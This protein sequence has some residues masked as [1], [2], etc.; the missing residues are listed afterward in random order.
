MLKR[1]TLRR[2]SQPKEVG[3]NL[4]P[5]LDTLVTLIAF[6]LY[7]MTFLAIVSIDSPVPINS[8]EK[9]DQKLESRPVQLTL[10]VNADESVIWSPF[11]RVERVTVPH[12]DGK[13]DVNAIHAALVRVKERYPKERQLV[14]APHPGISYD[15]IVALMDSAA[16]MAAGDT[17]IYVKDEATGVDQVE[18]NLFPEIVFG[19]LLGDNG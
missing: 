19:N 6:L 12:E 18:E 15:H 8:E 1:P 3:I 16:K 11:N 4:V 2:R 5:M 10:T 17:P 14:L 7:S 13:P 9:I